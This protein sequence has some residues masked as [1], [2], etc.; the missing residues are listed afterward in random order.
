MGGPR[1]FAFLA[2]T[3][4]ILVGCAGTAAPSRSG[5]AASPAAGSP[6]P[7]CT[8]PE[9]DWA[10]VQEPARSYGLAWNERDNAA[11]MALLEAVFA[12]D[13]TY[14]SPLHAD[15]I[16]GRTGLHGEIGTFLSSSPGEYFEFRSWSAG[17]LHHDAIRINWRLCNAAGQTLLEGQDFGVL[18]A[19]GRIRDVTGFDDAT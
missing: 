19:D 4:S 14:V 11:R 16:R 1:R 13:G 15:R 18:D 5:P 8:G 10:D 2:V 9:N 3:A 17:D 6:A 7:A 12:A